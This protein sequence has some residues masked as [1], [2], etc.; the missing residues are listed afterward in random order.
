MELKP[1]LSPKL[2]HK[3]K[4]TPQLKQAIHILQ[5]NLTELREL[6][7]QEFEENP[8]LELEEPL[9][10]EDIDFDEILDQ[11]DMAYYLPKQSQP[12]TKDIQ[13]KQNYLE[14][15]TTKSESLQ[16]NL[17]HQLHINISDK[18]KYKIGE[19]IIGN[20]NEEGYLEVNIEEICQSNDCDKKTAK[21]VL[22][23]IQDFYPSGVGARNLKESLEIQLR[24]KGYKKT[25]L[26][27]KIIDS[28]IEDLEKG[29]IKKLSKTFK[30]SEEKIKETL[31]EIA[32]LE[33][34][35]GREFLDEKIRYI[36]PDL[37][38]TE[39]KDRYEVKH[40]NDFLPTLKVSNYYKKLTKDKNTP[41]STKKYLKE[42]LAS[43]LW[44]IKAINQRQN[45]ILKVAQCIVDHQEDFFKNGE[46]YLKAL[47]LKEIANKIDM[48]E[49]TVSRATTGK[50]ISTPH[51]IFELKDL[52]SRE[53]HDTSVDKIKN[54]IKAFIEK[55]NI[56][57]PLTDTQISKLLKH[58]GI[59]IARRT[60][61]KY[62]D[63]L[64][65][66]P[67]HLRSQK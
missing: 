24:H 5:L 29:K 1:Q 64:K 46:G 20:I 66:L 61:A 44:L 59:D 50:Y 21:E 53:I 12:N 16:E 65:I 42:K 54:L 31:K 49:S 9:S 47:T 34:K 39:I 37:I 33:P 63:D 56:H 22:N 8:L 57:R 4:L 38:I 6:A 17:L 55:E 67:S 45:T 13:E 23:I 15:L 11:D 2:I 40:K 18:E 41:V 19:Y 51:G 30:V 52:F 35:C 7:E 28:H 3:L 32:Y 43:A 58:K 25:D 26:I 10:N 14:S 27:Y 62:R 60:V 36:Y 48:S